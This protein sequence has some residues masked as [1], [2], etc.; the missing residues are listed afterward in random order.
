MSTRWLNVLV[1]IGSLFVTAVAVRSFGPVDALDRRTTNGSPVSD[2]GGI[3][4]SV[5]I[6]VYDPADVFACSSAIQQWQAIERSRSLKVRLVYSRIPTQI[7]ARQLRVSRIVPSATLRP[8]LFGNSGPSAE[9]L[10]I[11]GRLVGTTRTPAIGIRSP[12]FPLTQENGV[13]K[14]HVSADQPSQTEA[15]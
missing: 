9:Y 2:L 15:P 12:L 14:R 4:D 10:M 13:P 1:F 7:E 6:L 8:R 11:R 3:S 5:L